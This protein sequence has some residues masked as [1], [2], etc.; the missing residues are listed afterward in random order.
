MTADVIDLSDSSFMN[1]QVNRF[2]VILHIQPVTD[3]DTLAIN[4]S[5]L[6]CRALMIISEIN[7]FQKM[8]RAVSLIPTA[9]GKL[10]LFLL[11]CLSK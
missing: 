5:C 11:R 9:L 4:R 6:S 2:A 1:D 3:I 10:L 7:F 8:I